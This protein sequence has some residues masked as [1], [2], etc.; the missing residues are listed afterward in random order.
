MEEKKINNQSLCS[1]CQD[2]TTPPTYTL[3]CQH[4]YH[5]HCIAKHVLCNHWNSWDRAFQTGDCFIPL[6]CPYCRQVPQ[7][8]T[9]AE[10]K[11]PMEVCSRVE[12]IQLRDYF[13]QRMLNNVNFLS[14]NMTNGREKNKF[15]SEAFRC[16]S[17]TLREVRDLLLYNCYI[18]PEGNGS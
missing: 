5:V 15:I 18:H 17:I 9:V 6:K 11:L 12:L 1:I 4:S 13:N 16:A 10:T 8:Q 7:F 3:P 14:R 2:D